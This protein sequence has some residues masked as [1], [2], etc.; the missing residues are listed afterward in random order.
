M[1]IRKVMIFGRPGSGKSTFALEL[2]K[3]L[4]IP[5][6]HL[7]KYFFEENWKERNYQEFLQIQQSIVD[8]EAWIIDGNCIKSL[9]M[10]YSKAD[11]VLYFNYPRWLC[12]FRI[13]KR[14]FYKNQ[15]IDDRAPNCHETIRFS[16]LKYMWSF[17]TR[18]KAQIEELKTTYP[19]VDL[20]EIRNNQ[21]LNIFK[22]K[23]MNHII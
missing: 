18:V 14:L 17:E 1:N 6:Y 3:A 10:R 11:L 5:L 2:H 12:Y 20:L 19:N 15:A 4:A 13:I 23:L 8:K 16:L 21:E 9:A 22:S 7:D